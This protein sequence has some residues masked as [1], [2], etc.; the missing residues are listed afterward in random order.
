MFSFGR[1]KP[2][3]KA[4]DELLESQLFDELSFYQTFFQDLKD[5]EQEVVIESPFITYQRAKMFDR[6]F[7]NLLEKGVKIY[8]ITRDPREH[9]ENLEVQS[10]EAIQYFESIGVQVLICAGNH[11]RKLAILDRKILWEGSLNILSQTRSREIMRRIQSK[12]LAT[13]MFHF[14]KL[15]RFL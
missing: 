11:H 14:L 1:Q 15:E 5:C 3:K 6:I 9:D 8:I 2:V 12:V 7:E 13:E 10:E 4:S